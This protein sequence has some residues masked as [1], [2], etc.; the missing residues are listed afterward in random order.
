MH[1]TTPNEQEIF[2]VA[3]EIPSAD[4]RAKYLSQVCNDD[5]A[6]FDRLNALLLAHDERPEFLEA[7]P[8]GLDITEESNTTHDASGT[9]IGPY[10]LLQQI[11]EGG[12][13]VVYMAEQ[14]EPIRRKV[15]LK[16]IKPGMDMKEVIARFEAERQAV[17][18]MDYPNIARILDAG[19]TDTG[20]PY[21]VMELVKGVT[22]T[23]YCDTNKLSTRDRL[24][25]FIT[26][27]RAVQHAHQ[28][29]VIHRDLKPSNVLVTLHDGQPVSKIIDFGV[30]S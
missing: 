21:F 15:A 1:T 27:C 20:R 29:G 3:I 14:T 5:I 18:L 2:Q 12:F 23:E 19:T 13:G 10:K 26:I 6:L 11:G 4:A 7:P 8:P 30:L 28:K 24:E 16:I 9:Q 17:A 25:L 22:I